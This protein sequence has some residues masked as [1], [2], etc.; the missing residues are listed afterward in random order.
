M[1]DQIGAAGKLCAACKTGLVPR[2][3]NFFKSL[4][5]R[6]NEGL[7]FG[8]NKESCKCESQNLNSLLKS[9]SKSK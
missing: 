2:V 7:C 1:C 6:E 8:L 5:L 9:N 4:T 3:E